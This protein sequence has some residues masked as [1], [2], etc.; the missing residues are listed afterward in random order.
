[1]RQAARRFL[2]LG[3]SIVAGPLAPCLR[4]SGRRAGIALVYHS[5]GERTGTPEL[6]LVP[7]HG[8]DLFEAHL[9]HLARTYRVVRA[10][11]L[12][13]AVAR[14]RR[15]ERFPV[16]ITFDDDLATHLRL[17]LP[18]LLRHGVQATF[19]LTGATLERP[20]YFWWQQL[21][22]AL[23]SDPKR[24]AGLL[25]QIGVDEAE[26]D[27]GAAHALGLLVERLEPGAREAFGEALRDSFG[28]PLEAGVPA[29][30]VRA[31]VD[32]GMTVGFHTRR[33]HLL[34]PLDEASLKAAF[35]DGREELERAVGERLVVVAYPHGRADERVAAAARNAGFTTGFTG[36]AVPVRSHDDPL[37]LG[38]LTPTYDSPRYFALQIAAALIQASG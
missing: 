34:P 14:R 38:R 12:P 24:L 20:Q 26:V 17:A 18:A 8:G 30:D 4:L 3:A 21:Q 25:R 2:R 5:L 1:M 19:F 32:A 35:E 9:R 10:E 36:V 6:E 29:E 31:L 11:D 23:E 13:E 15:G 37:L 16:A 7:P 33:H 22:Y 28:G 27:P